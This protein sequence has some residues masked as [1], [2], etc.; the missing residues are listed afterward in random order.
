MKLT[1][2]ELKALIKEVKAENSKNLIKESGF[3][4][5]RQIML[6]QIPS[7]ETLGI[8]T[9]ENPMGKPHSKAENEL[10]NKELMTDIR[11]MNYG[12]I[13]LQGRFGGPESSLL[14]PNMSRDEAIKLGNKHQQ[15]AVIWGQRISDQFSDPFLKFEYIEGDETIQTRSV[16]L[17]GDDA[18]AREDYF[19]A[20]KG[21]KFYIPFFDD[22]FEGAVPVEGGRKIHQPSLDNTERDTR[23]GPNTVVG[24][25]P[26]AER[27][28]SFFE[29]EV[30]KT[31]E[32]KTLAASIKMRTSL[33][34]ETDRTKKSKWHHRGMIKEEMRKLQRLID[35]ARNK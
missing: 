22:E 32:A 3:S 14:I 11:S 18:Q 12:P 33:L 9:A 8:L 5:V 31:K 29:D 28:I 26:I 16:S 21:R 23:L 35:Y 17:G 20:K 25:T 27:R 30:P 4:R 1:P 15:E 24:N 34:A 19:S 6:G 7:I 10:R 2:E 13:P